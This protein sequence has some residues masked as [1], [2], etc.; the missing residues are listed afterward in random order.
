MSKIR[1]A[2]DALADKLGLN[3]PLLARAQRRYKANRK[4]AFIAHAQQLRAEKR[5]DTLRKTNP[6]QARGIDAEALRHRHVAYQ[7]HLRA[8]F[9]LGRIK[10]LQQR[11]H[12]L[13]T[14]Q[15][16]LEALL[17][18][19]EDNVSIVGNKATGGTVHERLKAVAL[20]SAAECASGRRP[21]FY[22]QPGA[23]D[24]DHCI[25]GESYGE[26]SDCSSWFTSV[27]KSCGL[28]D[29]NASGYGSGYTGTLVANGKQIAYAEPGCAVIYGPGSG[30]HVELYCGP[31]D[32]TIGHGSAP[33]DAGIINLFGDSDYRFFKFV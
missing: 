17:K 25:T 20:K 3:R 22:S 19:L 24:V 33:V 9:W 10:A 27:Y 32:K 8:Q 13:E 26:R 15:A 7:N 5:A 1:Q 6:A 14:K 28:E 4:R 21:N 18:K 16:D 11:I 23:W 12:G 30:H 29:P 2:L 31:G